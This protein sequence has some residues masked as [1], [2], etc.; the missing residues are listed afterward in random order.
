MA[1]SASQIAYGTVI[2]TGAALAVADDKVGFRPKFVRLINITDGSTADWNGD[3]PDAAMAKQKG[4]ATSY[5]VADG[6]TPSNTGFTLG[7]DAD[8]NAAGDVIHYLAIG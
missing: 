1:S 8:L 7:A 4:A 2:G 3:M 5:V 6:I